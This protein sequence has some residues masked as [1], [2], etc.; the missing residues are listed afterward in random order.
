MAIPS[1]SLD[2]EPCL[3]I[4]R[5]N[6]SE[7][8]RVSVPVPSQP[9]APNPPSPHH[10]LRLPGQRPSSESQRS[11]PTN[12]FWVV[13]ADHL[14]LNLKTGTATIPGSFSIWRVD[15][16]TF[17]HRAQPS[18]PN[19]LRTRSSRLPQRRRHHPGLPRRILVADSSHGVVWRVTANGAAAAE[20]GVDDPASRPPKGGASRPLI[21]VNGMVVKDGVL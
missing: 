13:A 12:Q 19:R 7:Q 4:Q 2:R 14:D 20:V 11:L 5:L 6:L 16:S 1:S 10:H 3:P 21:G 8:P 17:R 15:L 18:P 9:D